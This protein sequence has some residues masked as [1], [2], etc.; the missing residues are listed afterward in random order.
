MCKLKPRLLR[1]S[2][3]GGRNGPTVLTNLAETG[4]FWQF[5]ISVSKLVR[6][7]LL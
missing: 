6:A 1:W 2:S 3:A 5:Y 7:S 4:R